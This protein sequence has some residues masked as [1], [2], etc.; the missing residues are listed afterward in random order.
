MP[1]DPDHV[2]ELLT[3]LSAAGVLG[4]MVD[5]RVYDKI[6]ELFP[7]ILPPR[8]GEEMGTQTPTEE[9]P[10]SPPPAEEVPA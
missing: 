8:E 9:P 4:M 3:S 2:A 6:A 10:A 7:D 5:P 1:T